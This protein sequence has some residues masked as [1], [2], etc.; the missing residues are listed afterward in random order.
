MHLRLGISSPSR[1]KDS[2]KSSNESSD[3]EKFT[4]KVA[5]L[6]KKALYF[7]PK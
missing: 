5:E 2:E 7:H 1:C 3:S 4:K 6:T